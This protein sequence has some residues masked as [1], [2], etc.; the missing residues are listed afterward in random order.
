MSKPRRFDLWTPRVTSPAVIEYNEQLYSKLL[1]PFKVTSIYV[2]HHWKFWQPYC[3][4]S[5]YHEVLLLISICFL[6]GCRYSTK[7]GT[8]FES[9]WLR[10][11]GTTLPVCLPAWLKGTWTSFKKKC[12]QEGVSRILVTQWPSTFLAKTIKQ[13]WHLRWWRDMCI[14]SRCHSPHHR[15]HQGYVVYIL[16]CVILN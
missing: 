16:V 11:F 12:C 15:T 3:F 2:T 13:T 10:Q 14:S 6:P 9:C 7:C 1:F 5:W 8:R 4:N